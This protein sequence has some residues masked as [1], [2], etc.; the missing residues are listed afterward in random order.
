MTHY[1]GNLTLAVDLANSFDVSAGE[2]LLDSVEDLVEFASGHGIDPQGATPRDLERLREV[3]TSLRD[4]L[5]SGDETA[6]V[7]ALN[8]L[9][10][11]ARPMPQ[12]VAGPDQNW[13]FHYA[14][15]GAPLAHRILA[16]A[17]AAALGEIR[18]HGMRRF[19]TCDS[20][21]CED[22]F[23]DQSRNR[24]RR[25]CSPDVCG[26]REAQRAYRARQAERAE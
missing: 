17:A 9:M 2:E 12:L 24:S 7:A 16:E 19:S 5:L 22:V 23:V 15:P 10:A 14:D 21:T 25:S 18:D 4:A 8:D 11:A 3:R 6:A 26:N 13:A 20:S 1:P